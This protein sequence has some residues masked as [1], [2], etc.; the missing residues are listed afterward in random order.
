MKCKDCK[1]WKKVKTKEAKVGL[2]KVKSPQ[3]INKYQRG[4]WPYTDINDWCGEFEKRK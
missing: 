3:N 4:I 2:C 1:W